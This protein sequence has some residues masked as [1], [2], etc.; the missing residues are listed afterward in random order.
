MED[1]IE[2]KPASGMGKS[3]GRG[4]SCGGCTVPQ[5]GSITM[6]SL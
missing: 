2:D 1:S 3:G 4:G 5:R 6:Q